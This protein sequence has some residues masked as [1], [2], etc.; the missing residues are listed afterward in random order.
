LTD[1][2]LVYPYFQSAHGKSIFRFPPLGL[3]Y[4]ASYLRANGVSVKIVDCTFMDEEEALK[5]ITRSEPSVIGIY[6]MYTMEE[7]V[8]NFD[9]KFPFFH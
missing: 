5:R 8:F 7:I 3:G 9:K 1:N 4:I 2:V 6:S